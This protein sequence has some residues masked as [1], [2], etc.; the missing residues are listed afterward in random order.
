MGAKNK[1]QEKFMEFS[2]IS[3]LVSLG[4]LLNATDTAVDFQV[5]TACPLP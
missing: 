1:L 3:Q 2:W 4:L 5:F